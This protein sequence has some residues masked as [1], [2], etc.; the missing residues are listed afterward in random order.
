MFISSR[1]VLIRVCL[2]ETTNLATK[3]ID[4]SIVYDEEIFGPLEEIKKNLELAEQLILTTKRKHETRKAVRL[5]SINWRFIGR[6]DE[7]TKIKKTMALMNSQF[8]MHLKTKRQD[9][10]ICGL[11]LLGAL[12]LRCINATVSVS[13]VEM[14]LNV[15]HSSNPFLNFSR[16]K[17]KYPLIFKEHIKENAL[18][19]PPSTPYKDITGISLSFLFTTHEENS[20]ALDQLEK[21]LTFQ[22][23][24]EEVKKWYSRRGRR[25][26]KDTR[27]QGQKI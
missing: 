1:T 18:S 26:K 5:L 21:L 25:E 23:A 3:I 11:R 22:K 12:T 14:S 24:R 7:S 17:T 10:M 4:S 6:K 8:N 27:E 15:A 2:M 20:H 19:I 13:M 9:L 16:T